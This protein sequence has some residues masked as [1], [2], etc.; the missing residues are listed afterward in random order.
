MRRL[1]IDIETYSSVDLAQCGVYRYA[2]SEDFRVLLIAYAYDDEPVRVIDVANDGVPR[3]L[4]EDIVSE[5]V[6]KWAHNAI[7]ERVCLSVLLARI[8]Y[9]IKPG[10]WLDARSWRCSLVLAAMSGLPI[11]RKS[12]V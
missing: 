8:G 7:F 10:Q 2:L 4:L 11:D 6:H 1:Y 12:V 9:I 5:Q 3:Q